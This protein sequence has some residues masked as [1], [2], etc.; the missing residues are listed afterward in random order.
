MK[1]PFFDVKHSKMERRFKEEL[2]IQIKMALAQRERLE[3]PPM[4]LLSFQDKTILVWLNQTR[5][6]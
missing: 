3:K 5:I 2:K 4:G 1:L 6:F